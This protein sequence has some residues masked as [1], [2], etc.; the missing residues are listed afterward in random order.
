M[1][2]KHESHLCS[3]ASGWSVVVNYFTV[4]ERAAHAFDAKQHSVTFIQGHS[5]PNEC[6]INTKTL[7]FQHHKLQT[8]ILTNKCKAQ[9]S[10]GNLTEIIFTLMHFY[11]SEPAPAIPEIACH[12]IWRHL[13][14]P[15]NQRRCDSIISRTANNIL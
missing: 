4:S 11:F 1:E 15:L 8:L 7:M 6:M 10:N 13:L 14:E 12:V 2:K 5:L 9:W 3:Y